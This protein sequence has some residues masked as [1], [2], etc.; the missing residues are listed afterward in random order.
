MSESPLPLEC[1]RIVLA[2]LAHTHDAPALAALLRVNRFFA[3]A[4]LPFLYANPFQYDFHSYNDTTPKGERSVLLARTLLRQA[5]PEKVT[6]LLREFYFARQDFDTD[7][8]NGRYSLLKSESY[9]PVLHYLPHIRTLLPMTFPTRDLRSRDSH[10]YTS[11]CLSSFLQTSGL[12]EHYRLIALSRNY[13]ISQYDYLFGQALR[14]D[15]ER[16]FTWAL[17]FPRQSRT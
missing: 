3:E 4:T 16:D 1:L 11:D 10:Y 13:D 5:P 8:D 14:T 6:D 12:E 15:V 2:N 17:V 9:V 7:D